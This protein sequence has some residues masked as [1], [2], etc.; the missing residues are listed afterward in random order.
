ML[1]LNSNIKYFL[2]NKIYPNN[3]NNYHN[4]AFYFKLSVTKNA[5]FSSTQLNIRL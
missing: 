5:N 2:A 1:N 4:H 3:K